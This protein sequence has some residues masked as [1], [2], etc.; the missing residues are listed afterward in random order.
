ML[1]QEQK[2][3]EVNLLQWMETP[4]YWEHT[5]YSGKAARC[6][7]T[8]RLAFQGRVNEGWNLDPVID[9]DPMWSRK[10]ISNW[11]MRNAWESGMCCSPSWTRNFSQWLG[12]ALIHNMEGKVV[13][14][15]AERECSDISYDYARK[16]DI[17]FQEQ[18]KR[19][20]TPLH[21]GL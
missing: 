18:D 15:H 16:R 4:A 12:A 21:V 10:A 7:R 5:P 11:L 3:M 1:K 9:A 17:F 20:F 14:E 19:M 6:A 2:L 8:L 13:T